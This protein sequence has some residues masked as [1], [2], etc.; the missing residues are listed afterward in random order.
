MLTGFQKQELYLACVTVYAVIYICAQ[1]VTDANIQGNG[2]LIYWRGTN[3]VSVWPCH[4]LY[5]CSDVI[6]N[7]A[8][9]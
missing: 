1:S 9:R 8:E 3:T 4:H 7:R 2:F 6:E 5:G